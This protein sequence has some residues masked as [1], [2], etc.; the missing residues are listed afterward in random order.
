MPE[1]SVVVPT[2]NR[3]ESLPRAIES[4]L[5]QTCGDFELIIVDDAST[6]ETPTVVEKFDDDR[7]RYHRFEESRGANAARNAGVDLAV[8]RY[9]S[10]LDS[11][12]EM[13]PEYL[14]RVVDTL[15]ARGGS[16]AGVFTAFEIVNDGTPVAISSATD[17]FVT[18]DEIRSDNV[19]GGFSCVTFRSSVFDEVGPLDETLQSS[20]DYDFFIRVLERGY[21][22]RGIDEV[23]VV[24]H[25]GENR[26]SD[27]VTRKLEGTRRFFEKHYDKL[28]DRGRSRL[29]Y[30]CAF[31]YAQ[32]DDFANARNCFGRAIRYQ[33]TRWLAYVHFVAS[34]HPDLY[35]FVVKSK[36]AIRKW[37][38]YTAR[39]KIS[40][41]PDARR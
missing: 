30:Y 37:L 10:F 16:C 13:H 33:P 27:D 20:Q 40:R 4:V 28:T 14:E 21:S 31:G 7:I 18:Y 19:V 29:Y 41:W 32:A 35:R 26:I 5:E 39:G 36:R 2:Y 38:D 15:D 9:V 17:G 23:L 24:C 6:D 11:D 12:D 3:A 22:I 8:G 1:T 25:E 34:F